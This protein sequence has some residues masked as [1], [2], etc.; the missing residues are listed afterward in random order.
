MSSRS[1]L[2][3][4][5]VTY[6][7]SLRSKSDGT[8]PAL[9]MLSFLRLFVMLPQDICLRRAP[10]FVSAVIEF[11]ACESII[12]RRHGTYIMVLCELNS[13]RQKRSVMLD[14]LW[15]VRP[16]GG[17]LLVCDPTKICSFILLWEVFI[18]KTLSLLHM[19][20]VPPDPQGIADRPDHHLEQPD[21]STSNVTNHI[22]LRIFTVISRRAIVC[23]LLYQHESVLAS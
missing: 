3:S 15:L 7:D 13:I 20:S 8:P 11:P 22:C 12:S 18:S 6:S 5:F 2:T 4:V 10:I 23:L 14:S 21:P 1:S 9:I 16:V 17:C 19:L